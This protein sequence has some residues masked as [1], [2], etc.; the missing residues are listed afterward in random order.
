MALRR[1]LDLKAIHCPRAIIDVGEVEV[2]KM[3]YGQAFERDIIGRWI[4][5]MNAHGG[6][7]QNLSRHNF[8]LDGAGRPGASSLATPPWDLG[9]ATTSW[10]PEVQ[11]H[12]PHHH[13]HR[14]LA[15]IEA[16]PF[17]G[18]VPSFDVHVVCLLCRVCLHLPLV[19][20]FRDRCC[21]LSM[22]AE[23]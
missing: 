16:T 14:R 7:K 2:K 12:R 20:L 17:P 22:M 11:A 6:G 8:A 5:G 18:R 9:W 1:N 19:L 13:L 10:E 15:F 21:H 4:P 23:T 3:I